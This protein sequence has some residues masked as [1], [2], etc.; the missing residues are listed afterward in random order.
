[1]HP[2]NSPEALDAALNAAGVADPKPASGSTARP[3]KVGDRS[4]MGDENLVEEAVNVIPCEELDYQPWIMVGHAIWGATGGSE[5]GREIFA[6][7]SDRY[8]GNTPDAVDEKWNSI[9]E[10]SVGAE[11]LFAEARKSGW[12]GDAQA[13]FADPIPPEYLPA[14]AALTCAIVA[15][16]FM[17]RNPKVLKPRQWLYAGHYILGYVSFT[18]APGGVGKSSLVILECVAIATGKALLP[19]HQ[20]RTPRCVWYINGEDPLEELER[21]IAAICLH[22]GISQEDIGDR[23]HVSSGRDADFT[24]VYES[25][26]E[27][28]ISEPTLA[29]L[30]KNIRDRKIALLVF[31]PFATFHR[32]S[33]NDNQKMNLIIRQLA[34]LAEET[35]CAIEAVHHTRKGLAGAQGDR[36]ADDARG[37]GALGAGARSLRV[38]NVMSAEEAERAGV[39]DRY[40]IFRVDV[41]KTNMTRRPDY[42][43][44]RRIVSVPLGNAQPELAGDEVGVVTAWE[45]PAAFEELNPEQ[46]AKLQ[47]A[48]AAG[49]WRENAQ[50]KDWAGKPVAEALGFD[51]HEPSARYAVK[52]LIKSLIDD[53]T[54]K[55]VTRQDKTRRDRA[56]IETG[57]RGAE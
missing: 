30:R 52:G 37:A 8:E 17:L 5:R 34:M 38:L 54:L 23:L 24:L 43:T 20:S 49:E 26:Q 10:T 47:E 35:G 12:T 48:V 57:K 14:P 18:I 28:V 6:K 39:A 7:W 21:R 45:W 1:M 51:L 22:Y 44:W 29:A 9:T 19:G 27:A 42:A 50:A 4:L 15:A 46:I 55:R 40:S 36:T 33:E 32:V 53:G 3:V 41:G 13:D 2:G 16:P 25:R 11:W 56:F 31:D